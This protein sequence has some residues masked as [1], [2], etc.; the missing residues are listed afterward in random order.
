MKI[1]VEGE[2]ISWDE[3]FKRIDAVRKEEYNR[4]KWSKVFQKMR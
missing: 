4:E 1:N 3:L 2:D